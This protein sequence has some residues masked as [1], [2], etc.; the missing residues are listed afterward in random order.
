MRALVGSFFLLG[1]L[2]ALGAVPAQA[3]E[4]PSISVSPQEGPPGT[5]IT[6]IGK[7]FAAGDTVYVEVFPGTGPDHGTIPL[8]TIAADAGGSFNARVVMPPE[9]F[10]NWGRTGG[11]YTVLAYPSSFGGRTAETVEAAPKVVFTL[12]QG[13][14]PPTGAGRGIAEGESLH[15]WALAAL[16][17]AA[18]FGSGAAVMF[19]TA[20]RRA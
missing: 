4:R 8:E 14:W 9:G 2:A 10:E 17:L 15:G 20:R 19:V 11:E 18:V 3:Q 12:T 5:P 6:V 16:G 1:A 7:G 13:A